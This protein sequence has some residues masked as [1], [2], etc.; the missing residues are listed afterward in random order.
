MTNNLRTLLDERHLTRYWLAQQ[1]KVKSQFVYQM[2]SGQR[3]IPK[4][5][6]PKIV[7]LL[8]LETT[9]ELYIRKELVSNCCGAKII[10]ETDLCSKCKEHCAEERI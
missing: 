6:E 7:E 8:D 3:P 10:D 1:L 5:M 4:D 2:C 9:D